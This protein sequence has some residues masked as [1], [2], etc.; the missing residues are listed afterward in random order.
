VPRTRVRSPRLV[1]RIFR[2][3]GAAR[4]CIVPAVLVVLMLTVVSNAGADQSYS[5]TRGDGKV[6]TDITNITVRNDL[7]GNISIQVESANPIV[8]N[9]AMAVFIDADS[10]P[11][12]GSSFGDEYWMYG[13]PAVG[14]GFLAWN[15]SQFAPAGPAS[16]SVGAASTNVTDFRI[17]RA[18]IG[19][20]AA[21]TFVV[22]SISIDPP[23][24][25]FWD[26]APDTG[27][28]RYTL[29]TAPPPP[30]PTTTTTPPSPTPP[31]PALALG[32]PSAKAPGIHA[33]KAFSVSEHVTTNRRPVRVTC[34]AHVGSALVRGAGHYAAGTASCTGVVPRGTAGKRLTGTITASIAGAKKTRAFGFLIRV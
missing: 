5:D 4:R 16:F 13:G 10:N 6:G 2:G 14:V 30:P 29:T 19:N 20:T 15:G 8:A 34:A 33:G 22:E 18:D 24:V 32:T 9:H 21:F 25:N 11:A 12:T 7:S 27:S 1:E 17:N 28:Y 3:S 26:F 23:N 31:P